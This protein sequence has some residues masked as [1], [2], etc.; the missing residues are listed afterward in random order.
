MLE[1]GQYAFKS[2][3]LFLR[4]NGNVP[5]LFNCTAGKD[6]TGVMAML[7]LLLLGVDN[8]IIAKEYELTTI[9]LIPNHQQIK[10]EFMGTL[11][12][13]K[14]TFK[15]DIE[16]FKDIELLTSEQMF[17]NLISS[18]YE[19]MIATIE[20]F[21]EQYGGIEKYCIE[22]L[23]LTKDD[24]EKI[25]GNLLTNTSPY[26]DQNSIWKHRAQSGYLL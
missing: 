12:N 25:K 22:K 23:G 20:L 24:L 13:F 2:V 9:G 15:N 3:F 5:V 11:Q 16:H 18:K 17:E 21:N 6:R 1:N 8:H 14:E 26:P 19:S 7:I 4:D 10:D